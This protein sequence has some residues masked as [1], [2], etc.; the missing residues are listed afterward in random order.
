MKSESG[1]APA[2]ASRVN[3]SV[4][5]VDEHQDYDFCP[6]AGMLRL[7]TH[8]NEVGCWWQG[9]FV[10]FRGIVTIQ[11]ED[12]YTRLDTV[13]GGRCHVRTWQRGYGDRTV[14]QLCRAFLTD[15]HGAPLKEGEDK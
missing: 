3:Q 10:D 7:S 1:R 6:E 15:L 2:A 13:A 12:T 8:N 4:R 11:M 9:D 14:A 5:V